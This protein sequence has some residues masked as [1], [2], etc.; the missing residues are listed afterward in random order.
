MLPRSFTA[1][2]TEILQIHINY[3]DVRTLHFTV[4]YPDPPLHNMYINSKFLYCILTNLVS[5]AIRR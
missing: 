5:F 3:P 2:K 1:T 4:H